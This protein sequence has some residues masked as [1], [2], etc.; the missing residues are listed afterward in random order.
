M[1]DEF[2][3]LL[4]QNI[5]CVTFSVLLV[6]LYSLGTYW[7]ENTLSNSK[8]YYTI[9]SVFA[10]HSQRS[11]SEICVPR[12]SWAI[13]LSIFLRLPQP[14]GPGSCTYFYQEQGS[15]VMKLNSSCDRWSVGQSILVLGSHLELITRFFF[16]VWQLCL[17]WCWTP[18][19]TRGWVCNLL[20]Y[21]FWAYPEQSFS[22]PI[23]QNSDPIL[24]SHFRLSQPGR[25]GPRIYIPQEQGDPLIPPSTG[26]PFRRL[27]LLAG[28][29]WRYSNPPPHGS[30]KHIF[31]L[32]RYLTITQPPRRTTQNTLLL[33][34]LLVLRVEL[35]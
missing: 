30:R 2:L 20:E 28:L 11:R 1:L 13:L 9:F 19:L 31:L 10:G 8:L 23:P 14:G 18:S 21:C 16:S 35:L 29:R 26:F 34:F 3:Y 32:L 27:L 25:S 7:T 15:P 33:T 12:D 6:L 5:H 17:Y 22:G 24:L 4:R